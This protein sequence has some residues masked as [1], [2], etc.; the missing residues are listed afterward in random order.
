[1]RTFVLQNDVTTKRKDYI[2]VSYG[3]LL[4]TPMLHVLQFTVGRLTILVVV[5]LAIICVQIPRAKAVSMDAFFQCLKACKKDEELC[6]KKC[7]EAPGCEATKRL[8]A[9]A[10]KS[11]GYACERGCFYRNRRDKTDFLD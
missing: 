9:K 10:C 1:M 4:M 8:C 7:E 2:P 11:A 5:L 6:M 3:R